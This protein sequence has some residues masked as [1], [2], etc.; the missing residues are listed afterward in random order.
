MDIKNLNTIDLFCGCG[1]LSLGFQ[2][3]GFNIVVAFDNWYPALEVYNKNFKHYAL[4]VDLSIV[5]EQA[6]S[7]IKMYK[8]SILI[9]GSPCQDF[10]S[11]GKRVE[12][13]RANLT[14]TFANIIKE[15]LPK[16]FVMENV[17]RY[18][19]TQT[20]NQV[21]HILKEC[22]YGLSEKVI[23]AS[24]C[25]VPQSRKRYFCIGELN[26]ND[27]AVLPYIEY[28]LYPYQ[29]TVKNYLG[30]SLGIDYYYR[31][32]RSYNRRAI[33][34]LDEPSAT[35]RGVN[36]G[37]P[38][39]YKQHSG[40]AV[41]ISDRVRA[42]TTIERSYIQTFPNTFDFDLENQTKTNLDQMIGNAVPVKM[43]ELVAISLREYIENKG[44]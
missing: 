19:R 24:Y 21:A 28:N 35:I 16:Y 23:D 7:D 15:L 40:D 32:P 12:S 33:F 41:P 29:T 26:G 9:G 39:T 27:G 14:V 2:N 25:G 1:G 30:D 43:A 5:G 17:D 10:S 11:S 20:Y 31:H 8:P 36:R 34:S 6:L 44:K 38:K 42:L 22:G 13:E 37:I 18:K 3:A 4:H